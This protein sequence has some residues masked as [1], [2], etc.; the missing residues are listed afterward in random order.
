MD[1]VVGFAQPRVIYW[2]TKHW[3]ILSVS[4][5]MLQYELITHSWVRVG[6][7]FLNNL[8]AGYS[9]SHSRAYIWLSFIEGTRRKHNESSGWHIQVKYRGSLPTGDQCYCHTAPVW[10]K[11]TSVKI[12]AWVALHL[13]SSSK[14][15][16]QV[17]LY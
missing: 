14:D 11:R 3:L 5:R 6:S 7:G 9:F 10:N 4:L 17:F 8:E 12:L 13:F 2:S 16:F 1:R 15:T